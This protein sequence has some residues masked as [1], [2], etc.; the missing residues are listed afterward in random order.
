MCV[1]SFTT[2]TLVLRKVSLL[3]LYANLKSAKCQ[4]PYFIA[5]FA[6]NYSESCI[7]CLK[8]WSFCVC[9]NFRV[10]VSPKRGKEIALLHNK[11][12]HLFSFWFLLGGGWKGSLPDL[13]DLNRVEGGLGR[14]IRI[15]PAWTMQHLR[16]KFHFCAQLFQAFILC[17]RILIF[18]FLLDDLT[19]QI[20]Y[21]WSCHFLPCYT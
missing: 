5:F 7:I 19:K 21:W 8:F 11:D 10:W 6:R 3:A 15:W 9:F 18:G 20:I 13:N 17:F 2:Y 4:M 1:R 12:V 16:A 14:N